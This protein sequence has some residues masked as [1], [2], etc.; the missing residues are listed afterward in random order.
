MREPDLSFRIPGMPPRKTAQ[1]KGMAADPAAPGG[2][3]VFTKEPQRMEAYWMRAEFARRLPEGWRAR[4][5]GVRVRVE[6][7][8]PLRKSDKCAPGALVPHTVRPD[9]DNLVKAL[10]DAMTRAG[11]WEDD[12]QV[13]DLHVRKFR[14]KTPRWTVRVRFGSI[15]YLGDERL[16]EKEIFRRLAARRRAA[17]RSAASAA[18]AA[19]NTLA[20]MEE[21]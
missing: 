10:L 18:I 7:V 12:A 3:R 11:V 6:L 4:R 21:A 20:G 9:A 2:V 16:P 8:Y 15:G 5:G 17:R 14:A 13:Y 1:E 19:T